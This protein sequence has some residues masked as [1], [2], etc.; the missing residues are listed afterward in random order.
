M[1]V[2]L[3]VLNMYLSPLQIEEIPIDR[4]SEEEFG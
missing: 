4:S 1:V 2:T 3:V